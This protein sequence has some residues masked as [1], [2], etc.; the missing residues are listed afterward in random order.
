[1]NNE[2]FKL[3]HNKVKLLLEVKESEL[4]KLHKESIQQR[5]Q[6]EHMRK[7]VGTRQSTDLSIRNYFPN[8]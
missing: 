3:E 5:D 6:I 1:M 2:T 8:E 4:E 7:E